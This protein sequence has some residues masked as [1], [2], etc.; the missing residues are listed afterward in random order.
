MPRHRSFVFIKFV[1]VLN[2]YKYLQTFK[3]DINLKIKDLT[4]IMYDIKRFI[5]LYVSAYYEKDNHIL[6][7]DFE[8]YYFSY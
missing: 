7:D 8:K 4:L 2:V 5:Y 1:S 6:Y 3:T